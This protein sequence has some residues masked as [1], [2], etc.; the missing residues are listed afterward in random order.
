INM[1]KNAS[2]AG[3]ISAKKRAEEALV[4]RE[5]GVEVD[6]SFKEDIFLLQHHH[7]LTCLEKT[8]DREF[9][10]MEMTF[11]GPPTKPSETPPPSPDPSLI[12][13]TKRG[14]CGK[15]FSSSR[16]LM[17]EKKRNL[18]SRF[19]VEH[20]ETNDIR[21]RASSASKRESWSSAVNVLD[22]QGFSNTSFTR[23]G[24][25]LSNNKANS[26]Q[27]IQ[28]ISQASFTGNLRNISMASG[29]EPNMGSKLASSSHQNIT[30]ALVSSPNS[31]GSTH[32]VPNA[33]PAHSSSLPS[34]S[35]K[36]DIIRIST[37]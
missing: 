16:K 2:S 34:S 6:D 26:I 10:E 9:V 4:A 36:E 21:M 29:S 30:T 8:T 25:G 33:L 35:D 17:H 20:Q 14:C 11:N 37:L 23:E 18:P 19:S 32:S 15:K 1:T 12:S 7:L 28:H 3:F 5:A 31:A 24:N 27:N 13:T 22:V